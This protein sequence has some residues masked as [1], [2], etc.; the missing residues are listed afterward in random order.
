MGLTDPAVKTLPH[1]LPLPYQHT[2][3]SRVGIGGIQALLGKA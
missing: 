2:A 3:D 1:R